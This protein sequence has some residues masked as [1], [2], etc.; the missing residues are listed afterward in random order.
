MAILLVPWSDIGSS[1]DGYR[2]H[3]QPLSA[4][5][6]CRAECRCKLEDVHSSLDATMLL[7]EFR[8]Y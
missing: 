1:L 5:S 6:D 2:E 8:E 7:I 4:P 3:A